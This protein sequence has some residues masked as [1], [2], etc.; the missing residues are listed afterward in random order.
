MKSTSQV[1]LTVPNI[2]SV[3][4]VSSLITSHSQPPGME[5]YSNTQNQQLSNSDD[6]HCSTEN[7]L[8]QEEIGGGIDI[9]LSTSQENDTSFTALFASD[10]ASGD[11]EGQS[12][13]EQG[14]DHQ[15]TAIDQQELEVR[16][17]V[18]TSYVHYVC[19]CFCIHP[20]RM[21]THTLV[22]YGR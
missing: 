11:F 20:T 12:M 17:I 3:P 6:E 2:R 15:G 22:V 19:M 13:M 4:A 18:R 8:S 10:S 14:T 16:H 1:S 9:N 21:H 7:Q 5:S